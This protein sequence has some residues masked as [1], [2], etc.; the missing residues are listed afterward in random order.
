[1]SLNWRT[2]AYGLGFGALD[3]I[4]LPIVKGVSMGWDPAWMVIPAIL[5]AGSPFL[6]LTALRQETL[7]I[8]NLVWDLTS[9]LVVTFIGLV[10]FA[11]TISPIKAL[12]VALSFVGLILMSWES[13]AVNEYLSR[14]FTAVKEVFTGPTPAAQPKQSALHRQRGG[15]YRMD[16]EPQQSIVLD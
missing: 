14:N 4:A 15:D 6:F 16:D 12:G 7:T 13:P 2:L 10:I 11:E 3:S 1:M 8:M 9:D 5:Y